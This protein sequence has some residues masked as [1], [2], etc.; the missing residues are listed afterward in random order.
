VAARRQM[1]ATMRNALLFVHI[2][3]PTRH[4]CTANQR[5]PAPLHCSTWVSFEPQRPRHI[6]RCVYFRQLRHSLY[7]DQ[8]ASLYA[9]SHIRSQHSRRFY[10]KPG[11]DYGSIMI[12]NLRLQYAEYSRLSSRSMTDAPRQWH[13]CNL[14]R[15]SQST[16][17]LHQ[18]RV[19]AQSVPAQSVPAQSLN[20]QTR[21][22]IFSTPIQVG[23]SCPRQPSR[24]Q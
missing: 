14:R 7:L 16:A 4:A 23:N 20:R 24:I 6:S 15:G 13:K 9:L 8:E 10:L 5:V 19:P 1:R 17:S 3:P 21:S 11:Y 18:V 22:R 2:L 12:K